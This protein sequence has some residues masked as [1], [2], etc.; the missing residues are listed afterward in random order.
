MPDLKD[1]ERCCSRHAREAEASEEVEVQCGGCGRRLGV[2]VPRA[3][4]AHM[5]ITCAV[6][7]T[8][9]PAEISE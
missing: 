4:I 5:A 8:T 1:F 9:T 6:C 3:F 7:G 2:T